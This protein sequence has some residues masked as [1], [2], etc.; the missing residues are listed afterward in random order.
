MVSTKKQFT[1]PKW[2]LVI[3][4]TA[5]ISCGIMAAYGYLWASF[6]QQDVDVLLFLKNGISWAVQNGKKWAAVFLLVG[7]EMFGGVF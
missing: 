3:L 2:I 4:G 5:L 1:A 7:A 6:N